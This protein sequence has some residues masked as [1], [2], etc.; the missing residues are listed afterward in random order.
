MVQEGRTSC[1]NVKTVIMKRGEEGGNGYLKTWQ[2]SGALPV[3]LPSRP[4]QQPTRNANG[5]GLG[6]G[7]HWSVAVLLKE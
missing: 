2:A 7:S 4:A 1:N 3:R 6:A 5:S